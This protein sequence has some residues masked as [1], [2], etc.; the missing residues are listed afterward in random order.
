MSR[1]CFKCAFMHFLHD[2][3]VIPERRACGTDAGWPREQIKLLVN[4]DGQ[5]AL[6]EA[7][8]GRQSQ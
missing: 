4:E 3:W 2:S 7:P 8:H 6:R 1:P 5:G